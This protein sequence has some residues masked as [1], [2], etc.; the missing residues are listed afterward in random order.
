MK[1][2]CFFKSKFVYQVPASF[3]P[4]KVLMVITGTVLLF[5]MLEKC[6]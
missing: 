4:V 5:W 3:F 2:G 6:T 1:Y